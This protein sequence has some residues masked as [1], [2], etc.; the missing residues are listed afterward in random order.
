MPVRDRG[1]RD[2][3]LRQSSF[4]GGLG[5]LG[6]GPAAAFHHAARRTSVQDTAALRHRRRS[7]LRRQAARELIAEEEET[8]TGG[9]SRDPKPFPLPE[10]DI[11]RRK[12]NTPQVSS[13]I[14]NRPELSRLR[15][16]RQST[17]VIPPMKFDPEFSSS[18]TSSTVRPSLL[19]RR[20]ICTDE[21]EP[22]TSAPA[23]R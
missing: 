8:V 2:R 7:T 15:G 3:F 13:P 12:S 22:S 19:P 6:G 10:P 21:T 17:P 1:A 18:P 9:S 20:S 14:F 11:H 23:P 16:R 4:A 5:A